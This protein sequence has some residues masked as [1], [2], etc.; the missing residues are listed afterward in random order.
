M[1]SALRIPSLSLRRGVL[2]T[3]MAVLATQAPAA[4]AQFGLP[5]LPKVPKIGKQEPKPTAQAKQPQGPAPEVT[6][7]T[8]SSVPP[9]WEGDVVFAGKNFAPNMKMRLECGGQNIKPKDFRVEGAERATFHLKIQPTAEETTCIIALE[10]PPAPPT[11][12]T[13]PAV[14]GSPMVVQVTGASFAIS[15]SSNLAKAYKACFLAEGELAPMEIMMKY[16]EAMQKGSQDECKLY[17]SSDSVK[18]SDK[19][20]AILDQ[21]ASAVRTIEPVLMMGNPMGAFRIVLTNGK[22]YNFMA[23]GGHNED[24][25]LDEQIKRKLKK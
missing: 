8:P 3:V 15:E 10:V 18:Y 24:D 20:K 17:V 21:P 9:G 4:M 2:F 22:I 6:A 23:S 14:Q 25:P 12:E 11:A 19:G 5:K 1:S 7:I 13:G 16:S